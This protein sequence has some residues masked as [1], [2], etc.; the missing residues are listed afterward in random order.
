VTTADTVFEDGSR[1]VLHGST[2]AVT[3]S[4]TMTILHASFSRCD[5]GMKLTISITASRLASP[6][7]GYPSYLALSTPKLTI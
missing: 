7:V 5:S 4:M 3:E 6:L 2:C 1:Y